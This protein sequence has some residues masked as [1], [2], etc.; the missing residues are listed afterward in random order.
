LATPSATAR[1]RH[2]V[3]SHADGVTASPVSVSI[4]SSAEFSLSAETHYFCRDRQKSDFFINSCRRIRRKRERKAR[5]E[6]LNLLLLKVAEK[7]KRQKSLNDD[8][9]LNVFGM[10]KK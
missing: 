10:W 7:K 1:R 2:S 4:L 3:T 9:A 6:S 5:S 8:H